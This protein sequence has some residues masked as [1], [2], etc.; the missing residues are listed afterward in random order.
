MRLGQILMPVRAWWFLQI[1]RNATTPPDVG[2]YL[3]TLRDRNQFSLEEVERKRQTIIDKG[4]AAGKTIST[5]AALKSVVELRATYDGPDR[6]EY[7]AD[8]D[9]VIEDF[10]KRHGPQIPI[11]EA[12]AILKELEARFGRV[13]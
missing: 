8:L 9:R 6:E 11:A 1:A 10:R 4:T 13:E 5:E 3:V 2:R 12:Y 7:V